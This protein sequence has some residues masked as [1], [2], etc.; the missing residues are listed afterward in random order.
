MRVLFAGLIALGLGT[1]AVAQEPT[2]DAVLR[3]MSLMM[4]IADKCP[5]YV[6]V[7]VKKAK[8]A[9]MSFLE[10]ARDMSG[11]EEALSLAQ[12]EVARRLDEAKLTGIQQWC[13]YQSERQTNRVLFPRRR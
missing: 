4:V 6:L 7:D 8:A 12:I 3:S 1:P 11:E 10:I 5:D 13:G 9:G 2:I